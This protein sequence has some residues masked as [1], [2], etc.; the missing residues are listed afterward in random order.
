[1]LTVGNRFSALRVQGSPAY[2]K[3]SPV[4][5]INYMLLLLSSLLLLL[6]Y[7]ALITKLSNSVS[8]SSL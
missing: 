2:T 5:Y 3:F 7:S 6:D 4:Y 8:A 1:M